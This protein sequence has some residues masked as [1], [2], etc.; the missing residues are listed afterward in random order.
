MHILLSK[1]D[2]ARLAEEVWR[3]A[4]AIRRLSLSF[5]AFLTLH[6][7]GCSGAAE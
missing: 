2:H 1:P 4:A 7:T 3:S 5:M 6:L